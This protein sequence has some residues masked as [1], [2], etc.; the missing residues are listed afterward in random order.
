MQ[1]RA[2]VLDLVFADTRLR[3][4]VEVD[5]ATGEERH[6]Y[7]TRRDSEG[8]TVRLHEPAEV[9]LVR[10]ERPSAEEL[11]AFGQEIDVD[12]D[13]EV[14][15]E[16]IL[17]RLQAFE[18]AQARKLEHFQATRSLHLRFQAAQGAFEASY[19]GEFF[20]RSGQGFD[21]VWSD[22]YVGGV[23]WKS[24]K[25]PSVPLIQPEK[26]ASLPAEIRLTKDYDYRLR[27]TA[28]VDGR[29]CWVID[30]QQTMLGHPGLDPGSSQLAMY[31]IP[32]SSR[33][34]THPYSS[35]TR[36]GAEMSSSFDS[37]TVLFMTHMNRNI[38]LTTAL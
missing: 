23:K 35:R 26:V 14:P 2:A 37:E 9:V 22:F 13:R 38:F 20:H 25:I 3:T 6:L 15:V 31:W 30:S 12:G 10:L 34:M 5:L 27:G 4:P 19:S 8:L 17:R 11:E 21:W 33:G 32:R 28:I 18:D 36:R 29:D 24:K 1:G 16:E 7:D